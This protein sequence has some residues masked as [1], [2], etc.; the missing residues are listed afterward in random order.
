MANKNKP[1]QKQQE[2]T[3]PQIPEAVIRAFDAAVTTD[4]APK[5]EVEE[6]E[7]P[8][9]EKQK[10]HPHKN[11]RMD[12]APVPFDFTE[13]YKTDIEPKLQEIRHICVV[14]GIPFFFSAAVKE[15]GKSTTYEIQ[16]MLTGSAGINL[17]DNR[18]ERHIAVE[19]GFDV[20]A[21]GLNEPFEDAVEQ[22]L[23]LGDYI[24]ELKTE[25]YEYDEENEAEVR[26][27]KTEADEPR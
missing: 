1:I 15:D 10:K 16:H 24:K 2:K 18:L 12:A 14:H 7:E 27:V 8:E 6:F 11:N 26:K 23:T 25:T 17:S 20:L 22:Q 9:D 5:S 13:I 19:C 3:A 4:P 21:P